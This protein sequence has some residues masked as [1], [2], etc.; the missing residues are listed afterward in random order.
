M[1]YLKKVLFFLTLFLF[2]FIIKEFLEL[3]FYLNSI[4][5]NVAYAFLI[6]LGLAFIFLVILPLFNILRYPRHFSPTKDKNLEQEELKIRIRRFRNNK[7]LKSINFDFSPITED[8]AGYKK[9]I[10]ELEK[11]TGRL[12]KKHVSQLFYSTAIAQNGFLDAVFILSASINHIKDI[13]I[14]YNGRVTNRDLFKIAG[15]IYYSI[16]IGGSEG[17]E[18]A[19]EE[20]FS[21][22]ATQTMK[23][24][25]FIDKILA[26]IADGMVNSVLLTRISYITE[27]YCKLH[28][29]E[30]DSQIYPSPGF[31]MNSAKNITQDF[32]EK[33]F[34]TMRKL[35]VKFAINKT[36]DFALIAINPIGYVLGKTIE[37]SDKIDM[38]QKP[39]LKEH[40][41]LLGNPLA[42]G[43]EKLIKSF[44]KK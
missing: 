26:S 42:Y 19:T 31:V 13:F 29:I 34:R 41:K 21:K 24:I 3:Y 10:H 9:I 32:V 25:P 6:I 11:E 39:K 22:F 7:Y 12:R 2:Y 23:S 18:Y 15:K 20:I 37:A 38:E 1:K 8:I 30:S 43:F 5:Q 33:I 36:F 4:H 16:A 27:N 14:L 35:A 40:A 44:K 17:V 28:Y